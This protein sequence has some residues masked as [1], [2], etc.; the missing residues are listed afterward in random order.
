VGEK[1]EEDRKMGS[2]R[3]QKGR[4]ER[5]DRGRKQRKKVLVHACMYKEKMLA[6]SI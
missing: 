4:R 1:E 3:R 2:R 6:M 5:R